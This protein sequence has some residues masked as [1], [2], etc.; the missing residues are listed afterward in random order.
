MPRHLNPK[1]GSNSREKSISVAPKYVSDILFSARLPLI[2]LQSLTNEQ[3]RFLDKHLIPF[4][5]ANRRGEAASW[6]S[7]IELRF[8]SHFPN[9]ERAP[10]AA[11]RARV[12]ILNVSTLLHSR[13]PTNI[14]ARL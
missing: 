8:F 5:Y 9:P 12:E 7:G 3:R 2:I 13:I 10:A 14:Y 11:G 6:I 4:T 1:S